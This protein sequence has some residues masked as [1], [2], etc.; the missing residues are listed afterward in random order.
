[1]K[2][3]ELRLT[4]FRTSQR[5]FDSA[6]KL[7]RRS[8]VWIQKRV[9]SKHSV[10]CGSPMRRTSSAEKRGDGVEAFA[11]SVAFSDQTRHFA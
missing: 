3:E 8:F 2:D 11:G 4:N 6:S 7:S 1:V 5:L 9:V 10:Y